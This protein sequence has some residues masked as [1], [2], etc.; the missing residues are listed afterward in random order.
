MTISCLWATG[1]NLASEKV[2]EEE[3][4]KIADAILVLA[5]PCEI[6]TLP[7]NHQS[8]LYPSMKHGV[9]MNLLKESES[10][11]Y[12]SSSRLTASFCV[13]IPRNGRKT[14]RFAN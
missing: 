8:P 6:N 1:L 11:W 5:V 14:I 3:K 2:D 9:F 7:S 13:F 10:T 12:S 4:I